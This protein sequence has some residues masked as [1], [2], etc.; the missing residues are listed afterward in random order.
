VKSNF[1]LGD[2][3]S[4]ATD[5]E[6]I[7]AFKKLTKKIKIQNLFLHDFFDGYCISHHD[8]G[9]PGT[10][11]SKYMR[12]LQ[13][14][15]TEIKKGTDDI[16]MLQK[17]VNGKLIMIKSNHDEVLSRYLVEGRYVK[18]PENHYQSLELA[19][20]QLEGID[21]LKYAY[22]NIG[23]TIKSPEK[24]VWLSRDEEYKIA[25]VECGQHGDL[26]SNGSRG[27]LDSVERAYGNCVVGHS[28]SAAIKRGVFRVGTSTVKKLDYSRGP[29][30][31]THT[32][33]FVYENGSRQLINFIG[34]KFSA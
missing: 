11:T 8:I 2:W 16:N 25:G 34:G 17:L 10:I 20:K 31:W 22:E 33:C 4:G 7:E 24:I 14:L 18:D 13:S 1:V 15:E 27:S 28:H 26:G 5:P 21:P 29:S 30:S 9:K 3:H 12:G 6:V 32:G 23:N 19:R